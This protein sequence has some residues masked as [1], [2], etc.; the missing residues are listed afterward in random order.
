M[1][2]KATGVVPG[3]PDM[4]CLYNGKPVGIEFKTNAGRT[5]PAQEQVHQVWQGAGIE[6]YLVRDETT[7]QQLIKTILS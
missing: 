4:I 1:T 6:V 7:F 2:L 3:I 5:S